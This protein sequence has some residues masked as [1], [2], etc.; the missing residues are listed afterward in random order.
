MG[1]QNQ[2]QFQNQYDYP[3]NLATPV[4]E[5]LNEESYT[6]NYQEIQGNFIENSAMNNTF[7]NQNFKGQQYSGQSSNFSNWNQSNYLFKGN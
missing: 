4:R 7:S 6:Q 2:N 3:S 1:F 5:A